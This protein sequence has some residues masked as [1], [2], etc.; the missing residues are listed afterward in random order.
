MNVEELVG[1]YAWIEFT[2]EI[3]NN[4]TQYTLWI[5]WLNGSLYANKVVV[6]DSVT[7]TWIL[8]LEIDRAINDFIEHLEKLE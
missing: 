2:P 8:E 7:S 3:G 1:K 6:I 4:T 5:N